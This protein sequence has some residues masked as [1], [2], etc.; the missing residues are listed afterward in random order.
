MMGRQES[1]VCQLVIIIEENCKL[2][3]LSA[4]M[5]TNFMMDVLRKQA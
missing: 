2:L 4:I 5:I 3:Q 1:D